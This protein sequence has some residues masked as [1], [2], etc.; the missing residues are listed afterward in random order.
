MAK[1][2]R[3]KPKSA[4]S[5][6]PPKRG[7]GLIAGAVVIGLLMLGGAYFM[8]STDDTQPPA[9]AAQVAQVTQPQAAVED[10]SAGVS[11]AEN[12]PQQSAEDTSPSL[13]V[14]PQVGALAPGF[15]LTDTTGNQVS[16]IDYRGKPVVVSFFHTW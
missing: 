8:F 10:T 7:I 1:R 4:Q 6:I 3:R 9:P 5:P 16:L 2:K 15:T 13:P 12:V 11:A 14:A